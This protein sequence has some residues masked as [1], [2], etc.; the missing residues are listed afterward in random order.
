MT[1]SEFRA[2]AREQLTGKRWNAALVVFLVGLI[3]AIV[4]AVAN[5]I[6]PGTKTMIMEGFYVTQASW[7]ASLIVFFATTFLQLGSTSYF[8]KIARGEEAEIS[9]LFSK[10]NLLL[11]VFVSALIAGIIVGFGFVLL[12]IPGIILLLGYVMMRYVY[13]DNPEIGIIEALKKSREMMKGHKWQ[14][15]C[16]CLSFIGWVLLIPLTFGI[17]YFWLAPYMAV[18]QA[19]FY[20]SIK[21]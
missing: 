7:I 10:G 19:N 1:A 2:K 21:E 3:I 15:F 20:D 11:K 18:A 4:D 14:Y 16:L 9:E 8:L 17:L 6:F 5:A 13:L 12:I